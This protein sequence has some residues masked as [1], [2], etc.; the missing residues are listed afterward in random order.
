[1][2]DDPESQ[3]RPPDFED[4]LAELEEIV[5]RLERGEQKLESALQDFERG[6]RLVRQCTTVLTS[7]EQRVDKLVVTPD[8][9]IVTEPFDSPDARTDD[10]EG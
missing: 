10:D 6:V 3:E 7:M 5:G 2:T 1:M 8:G 4:T 9:E